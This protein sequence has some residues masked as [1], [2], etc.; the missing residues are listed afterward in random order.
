MTPR[1]LVLLMLLV[2]L[3]PATAGAQSFIRA[4]ASEKS[5]TKRVV[6]ENR[7][8]HDFTVVLGAGAGSFRCA[9]N[10]VSFMLNPPG[11]E[12]ELTIPGR[13]RRF[14][15]GGCSDT[16]PVIDITRCRMMSPLPAIKATSTG[17]QGGTI[18]LGH[19]VFRC[20][21]ARSGF[22]C[23]Y[24]SS[25]LIPPYA[26]TGGQLAL[27][28]GLLTQAAP[29]DATDDLGRI[30]GPPD[31]AVL[32]GRFTDLAVDG[33]ARSALSLTPVP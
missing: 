25:S 28:V 6:V 3:L 13:M 18:T 29:P 20:A 8:T 10:A 7:S 22:G 23:Y 33:D 16:I 17:A 27:G 9:D 32:S 12:G 21:V 4:G 14:T 5:L 2:A 26:N 31:G 30:C 19:T 24:S 15:L 1:R 11:G